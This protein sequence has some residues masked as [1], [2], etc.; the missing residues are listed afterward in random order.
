[1]DI[2]GHIKRSATSYMTSILFLIVLQV[3]VLYHLKHYVLVV[4]L[5]R[6]IST[7]LQV[8]LNRQHW[9]IHLNIEKDLLRK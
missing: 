3:A 6:M 7:Q 8:L 1:M 4:M 9:C 2:A 5:L